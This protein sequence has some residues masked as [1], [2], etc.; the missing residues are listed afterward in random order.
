M[1]TGDSVLM[2]HWTRV[3]DYAVDLRAALKE[4]PKQVEREIK[5]SGLTEAEWAKARQ[6]SKT[7]SLDRYTVSILLS[8]YCCA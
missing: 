8:L 4:Y 7:H 1:V 6:V 5:K 3:F 2:G